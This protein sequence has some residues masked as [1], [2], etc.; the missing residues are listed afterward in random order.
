MGTNALR[1]PLT[2]MKHVRKFNDHFAVLVTNGVSTMW[3]AYLFALLAFWGGTTVNWHKASEIVQW[4]SQTFL[5]LVLLSIIMVG[6]KVLTENSDNMNKE[7]HDAVME[8]LKIAKQERAE[9]RKIH[10]ELMAH[11]K[12]EVEAKQK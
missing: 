7:M 6:Q 3:C 2:R 12:A 10:H 5:Q 1:S 8:E 4:V 11:L 9:L